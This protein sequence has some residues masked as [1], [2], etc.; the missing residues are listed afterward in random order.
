MLWFTTIVNLGKVKIQQSNKVKVFD[1][2]F[3]K[4]ES[5]DLLCAEGLPYFYL[6][7]FLYSFEALVKR[8]SPA[9]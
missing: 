9:A 8:I 6:K 7:A 4:L 5:L 3:A 1:L 2:E